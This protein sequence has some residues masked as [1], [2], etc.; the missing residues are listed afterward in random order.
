[1]WPRDSLALKK[2]AKFADYSQIVQ[3]SY[4][5]GATKDFATRLATQTLRKGVSYVGH[6]FIV[7]SESLEYYWSSYTSQLPQTSVPLSVGFKPWLANCQS[8]ALPLG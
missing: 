6:W 3:R 2:I 1:M 7:P 4:G 8:D 5:L